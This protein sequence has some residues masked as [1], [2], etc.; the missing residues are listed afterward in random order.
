MSKYV[1]RAISDIF[2]PVVL[3]L[4]VPYLLVLHRTLD[5]AYS[6]RWAFFSWLFLLAIG[7]VMIY[8]VRRGVFSDLDVSRREQRPLLFLLSGGLTFAY[9]MSVFVL[10]GPR[11]LMVTA[12]GILIGIFVLSIINTRLKASIHLATISALLT[13]LGVVYGGAYASLFL[14]IP[15]IGWARVKTHRHTVSETIVG[16]ILGALLTL[17]MYILVKYILQLA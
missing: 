10:N 1:A 3:L 11:V 4:P 5:T 15:V 8:L 9:C 12:L 14:L 7:L 16:S 2:N 13:A 17:F 6:F